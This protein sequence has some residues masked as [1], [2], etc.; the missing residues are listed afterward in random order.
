MAKRI[1]TVAV[2]KSDHRSRWDNARQRIAAME[3]ALAAKLFDPAAL[4][5]VQGVI[6]ANDA[7]T[8][9]LLG[10][11]CASE[12]HQDALALFDQSGARG[13]KEG[14][15]HLSRLLDRNYRIEYSG[16]PVRQEDAEQLSEHARRFLEFVEKNLS[17]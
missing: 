1:K 17:F 14:R 6:A 16:R 3:L 12:R 13:F 8:I 7:L 10:E 9:A 4:L 2:E 5:A 11:R 15:S